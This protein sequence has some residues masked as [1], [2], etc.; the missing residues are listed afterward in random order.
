MARSPSDAGRRGADLPPS[1]PINEKSDFRKPTFWVS[2]VTLIVIAVYTCFACN[3]VK[4][5]KLQIR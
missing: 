3:Q 4:E 2:V 5:L 1:A